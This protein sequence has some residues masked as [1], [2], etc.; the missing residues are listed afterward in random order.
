M[1]AAVC[2]SMF[3]VNF[4]RGIK[5]KSSDIMGMNKLPLTKRVQILTMLC[6]GSSMRSIS[7]VADVSI[8]I[9]SAQP[10]HVHGQP[11]L[12]APHQRVL[13]EVREPRLHG[14]ALHGL[15]QLHPRSQD[16]ENLACNGRLRVQDAL[17]DGTICARRWT[18]LRRS[19]VR[20]ASIRS[21]PKIQAET[22]PTGPPIRRD[23]RIAKRLAKSLPAPRA[24]DRERFCR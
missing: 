20:V 2:E 22:L 13:K 12:Y 10:R 8:N 3:Y 9:V 24:V 17:V 23:R 6:E 1:V 5:Y 15:A 18:P 16:A 19:R 7:R 11:P 14:R 21:G 4:M